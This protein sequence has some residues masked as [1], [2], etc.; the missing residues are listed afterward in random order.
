LLNLN[1]TPERTANIYKA[2]SNQP[3]LADFILIGGTA[4]SIQIGH[5]LSEDLDFWLPQATLNGATIDSIANSLRLSGF[6]IQLVTPAAKIIQAKIN[7][8]DLL[9][10]SRDYVV[11]GVKVTF[12]A[13][14]DLPYQHFA[15]LSKV[16]N[17]NTTFKVMSA[18]AIFNMK[19]WLI[20]KRTRSR[21][22]FD[23]LTMLQN[24]GKTFR[25]ILNAGYMADSSYSKAY[26]K[27][28]L[29]G[30]VPLDADDEG[31][32]SISLNISIEEIYQQLT[33]H[34]KDYEQAVA[35]EILRG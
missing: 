19:S 2:L 6:N 20:S 26:A 21:D 12:F 11:D 28:V 31:F 30:N 25:D 23:L 4:L 17:T 35:E 14:N 15:T 1:F 22:L 34:L 16:Q 9:S 7:G 5:R 3:L 8:Q 32:E 29:A 33:A 10:I 18:E 13:R 24:H 27:E